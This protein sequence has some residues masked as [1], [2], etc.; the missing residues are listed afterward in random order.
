MAT[1]EIQKLSKIYRSGK[2]HVRALDDV[3]F[4]A[5]DGRITALVGPSGCGKTTLLRVIAGLE[6]PDDGEIRIDRAAVN[7]VQPRDRDVAMVFQNYALY[8]HMTVYDNMAFG[9][10]VRRL[11]KTE[12]QRR[13]GETAAMLKIEN[14][15][16]RKP[17]EL[18]GGQ[19]QRVAIGRALVRRPKVF[20]MDEPL[21]NL[22]AQL[23]N[24]MRIELYRLARDL[25]WTMI[26]VTHDQLE[27]MTLAD[28]MVIL[29]DG[30]IRQAGS[31]DALFHRPADTFV[32]SFIGLPTMN[33]L[34]GKSDGTC[35][36][37]DDGFPFTPANGIPPQTAVIG[38][39]PDRLTIVPA[40]DDRTI[41]VQLRWVEKTGSDELVHFQWGAQTLTVR[42]P[43]SET[44]P[45][46]TGFV[47]LAADH[48]HYFDAAGL[49]L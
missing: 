48:L 47:R 34:R 20:L 44:P 41:A 15:L 14:L 28:S 19:R 45:P 36:R 5:D 6:T 18:S 49:R 27:A 3:S 21:S 7:H 13:I 42:R 24:E 29:K 12:I 33:L 43:A 17:R 11:E 40:P 8:P 2:E 25:R 1:V 35:W 26:Y 16:K 38:I 31:P 39:R 32:A 9:L 23:R 46:Q 4:T 10:K 37:S 22:D 30:T